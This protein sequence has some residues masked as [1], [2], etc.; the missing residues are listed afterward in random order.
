MIGSPFLS[1]R[2][3]YERVM[4]G[5]VDNTHDDA[6]THTVR[7]SDPDRSVEVRAV[8]TAS[9]GYEVQEASARV[10]S[11][12]VDPGIVAD[13][14]RLAGARMVGG[15]TKCLAELCGPREG[16]GLFVDAGIEVARLARQVTRMP[17]SAV[18]SLVP[19]DAEACWALDMAGWV[20]LPDSC[21]TYSPAGRA[22]F[23]TRPVSSPMVPALYS[24]PPGARGIFTR[25]KVARLVLTGPRLHLFHSMHDN[26]HGFDVH[27]EIDLDRETIVAADSITSR[28]PYA[29]I[30]TE[31]QARIESL[32]GQAVDAALRK[33]IQSQIG[34]IGGC[35]QLYDLTSDLLKLLS[36]HSNI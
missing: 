4:E 25:R 23:G 7:L 5:R 33:R 10:L 30:C 18:A 15:F 9:P 24:P 26:V 13:L 12:A 28:L 6:F 29:G 19:G 32:R 35:A 2:D 31:P 36:L 22:L 20:D 3:R 27:Y 21:F 11:G 16:A 8:C 14:P 34:G 1:G 17:A